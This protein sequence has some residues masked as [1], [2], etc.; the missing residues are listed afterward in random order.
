MTD[1]VDDGSVIIPDM[2]R[3]FTDDISVEDEDDDIAAALMDNGAEFEEE[4]E[5]AASGRTANDLLE[6]IPAMVSITRVPKNPPAASRDNKVAVID[7]KPAGMKKGGPPPPLLRVGGLP[8][9]PRLKLGNSIVRTSGA[10]Q[11]QQLP[12]RQPIYPPNHPIHSMMNIN[13][14]ARQ[15]QQLAAANQPSGGASLP[16]IAGTMSLQSLRQASRPPVQQRPGMR[17]GVMPGMRPIAGGLRPGLRPGTGGIT[18]RT[19][20]QLQAAQLAAARH[21]QQFKQKTVFR[22]SGGV[23][24]AAAASVSRPVQVRTVFVPPP[25]NMSGGSLKPNNAIASKIGNSVAGSSAAPSSHKII[26]AFPL[27]RGSNVAASA[28]TI[29]PLSNGKTSKNIGDMGDS[30]LI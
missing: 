23:S 24:A 1:D 9:M 26:N 28:I 30:C 5:V 3:S 15:Q 19:A 16:V 25:M 8:P 2:T 29:T 21:Q 14:A 13:T 7:T 17:M 22:P 6:S 11:Q 20:N 12:R 10:Q 27:N 4:E 18:I